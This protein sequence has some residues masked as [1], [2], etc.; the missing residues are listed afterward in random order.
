MP[1]SASLSNISYML[2]KKDSVKVSY[3]DSKHPSLAF[4]DVML[5]AARLPLTT[6]TVNVGELS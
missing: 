4:R 3:N 2:D 5:M 1:L 6:A